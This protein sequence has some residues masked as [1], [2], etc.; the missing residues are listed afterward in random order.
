M[1]KKWQYLLLA[2]VVAIAIYYGVKV[3]QYTME[4]KDSPF[5]YFAWSEF[6]SPDQ[7]GSGEKHMNLAFVSK[8]DE[9]RADAGIPFVITSGYRTPAHNAK[10]GGVADSSHM[11]GV[12][13]DISA[14]TD[15]IRRKIAA[16]AIKH[17]VTRI[18]WGRS[19]IHLDMDSA[20]TQGITWGY[21]NNYPSFSELT[22]NLA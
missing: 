18:G 10:V 9:I 2:T 22:Q 7:P 19:F 8:L 11:K 5:K 20:K 14:P 1:A 12:A 16:A 21:G 15:G 4:R 3:Y 17:G 6:D 13:V